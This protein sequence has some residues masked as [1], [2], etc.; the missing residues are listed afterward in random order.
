[1]RKILSL[2]LLATLAGCA[3]PGTQR[4]A[5]LNALVGKPE[6]DLVR[7]YGVPSRAFDTGGSRFLA[8]HSSRIATIPGAGGF[9]GGWGGGWGPGFGPAWGGGWGGGFPPE[10]TQRDCE[11]TF[12]LTAGVVK[13]WTLRGNDCS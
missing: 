12:E 9:Y 3:Y 13:S 2:A 6:S 4:V 7:V 10:I 11:T 1:M 5:G 8:Y